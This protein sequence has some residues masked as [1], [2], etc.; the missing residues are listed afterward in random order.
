MSDQGGPAE[1]LALLVDRRARLHG[2]TARLSTALHAADIAEVVI[3]EGTTALG[4]ASGALWRVD[5]AA[6]RLQLLRSRNYPE[7]AIRVVQSMP[8]Q[9]GTAVAEAALGGEPIW[10]P[11]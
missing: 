1:R 3:D 10:I 11:S 4:A 7:E 8:L 5:H 6:G 9:P 2:L